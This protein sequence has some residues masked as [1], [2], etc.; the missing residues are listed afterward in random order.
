LKRR[1]AAND[2]D[3]SVICEELPEGF[4]SDLA[5]VPL[6]VSVSLTLTEDNCIYPEFFDEFSVRSIE[7]AMAN[8][9]HNKGTFLVYRFVVAGATP[10]YAIDADWP[11]LRRGSTA[12]G[13]RPRVLVSTGAPWNMASDRVVI[14]LRN[15][16]LSAWASRLCLR[17]GGR[18][19]IDAVRRWDGIAWPLRRIRRDILQEGRHMAS[20]ANP[21][22]KEQASADREMATALGFGPQTD[23]G[24]PEMFSRRA[25]KPSSKA[26]ASGTAGA[27][28]ASS[29]SPASKDQTLPG[30]ALEQW[31][32]DPTGNT[33]RAMAERRP[34]PQSP[35][36][37]STSEPSDEAA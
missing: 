18:D 3:C 31:L 10:A 1:T 34:A 37:P 11:L 6:R 2:A 12:A 5:A 29:A 24:L 4:P 15:A 9:L 20:W 14:E 27:T 33:Q 30:T 32:L 19:E 35:S 36:E 22:A 13:L 26:S 25:F 17:V 16:P 21:A 28:Q 7:G 8:L 23:D